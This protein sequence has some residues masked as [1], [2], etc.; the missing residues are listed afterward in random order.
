M[1]L[2]F[3]IDGVFLGATKTDYVSKKTGQ[4]SCFYNIAV[5]QGGEVGSVPCTK[6]IYDMYVA[7]QLEE[8]KPYVLDANF[9]DRF[10][11]FE[12]CGA[13]AKK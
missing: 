1:R 5:K 8:F 3:N 6:D 12:V 9:D 11:R 4:P 2:A 10:G 7:K 13:H